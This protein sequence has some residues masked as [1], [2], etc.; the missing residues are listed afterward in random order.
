MMSIVLYKLI[1]YEKT[2]VLYTLIFSEKVSSVSDISYSVFK[3]DISFYCRTM[4]F[5]QLFL[6]D[7]FLE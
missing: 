6:H 7:L 5:D 4:Q 2:N 3:F 1:C